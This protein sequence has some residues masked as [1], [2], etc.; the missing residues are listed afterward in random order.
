VA[1]GSI[2]WPHS[3]ATSLGRVICGVVE[4]TTVIVCTPV[5]VCP[6]ASAAVHVRT[7]VP[8]PPHPVRFT[9]SECV[10]VGLK[11]ASV[12]VA[13]P[14]A[15]GSVEWPH[16]TVMSDGT[17]RFGARLSITVIV[18]VAATR[19][20]QVSVAVHVR[21]MVPPQLVRLA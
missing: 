7:I 3:T 20:P 4:S 9:W 11:Q 8:D 16:S 14:V 10:T 18:W 17:L 6:Q 15:P 13:W 5:E 1:V 19:F 21:A 12:A 2:E